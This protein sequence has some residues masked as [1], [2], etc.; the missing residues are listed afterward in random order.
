MAS[1]RINITVSEEMIQYFE[2]LGEEM[3]IPRTSAIVMAMKTYMDQQ[4]SL[5]MGDVYKNLEQ[6]TE[7][8]KGEPKGK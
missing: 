5:E 7:L 8:L 3:G 1:K 4:K 2:K 6:L